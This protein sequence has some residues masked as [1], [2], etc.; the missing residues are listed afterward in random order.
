MEK[1]ELNPT[2]IILFLG[3]GISISEKVTNSSKTALLV[4]IK[5]VIFKHGLTVTF[6]Q[7]PV[8]KMNQFLK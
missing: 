7:V 8:F 6:I 4:H 5:M 2:A 3:N 1:G